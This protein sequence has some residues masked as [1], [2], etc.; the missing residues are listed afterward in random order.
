MNFPGDFRR[1]AGEI[2]FRAV[3]AL[4]QYYSGR[5]IAALVVVIEQYI[6]KSKIRNKSNE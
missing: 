2:E 3:T 6:L 1:T 4:Q 5:L